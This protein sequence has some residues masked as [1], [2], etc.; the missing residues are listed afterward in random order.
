MESAGKENPSEGVH[1]V[2]KRE[3]TVNFKSRKICNGAEH[4]ISK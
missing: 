4:Y 3:Q 2:V 1:R